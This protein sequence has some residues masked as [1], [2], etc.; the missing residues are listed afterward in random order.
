M[1]NFVI[2]VKG[3][4]IVE[5]SNHHFYVTSVISKFKDAAQKIRVQQV[6]E[7]YNL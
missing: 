3:K 4:M 5:A 6:G 2:C 1:L 7:T